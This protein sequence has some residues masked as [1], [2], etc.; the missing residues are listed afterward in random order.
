MTQ[1]SRNRRV[2]TKL[3]A[4]FVAMS[5]QAL[6]VS[7]LVLGDPQ[8]RDWGVAI[9]IAA[10]GLIGAFLVARVPENAVSWLLA[11]AGVVGAVAGFTASMAPDLAPTRLSSWQGLLAGLEQTTWFILLLL[12]VGFMPLY[13]PTGAV[14]SRRWRW[15][16]RL[17]SV[18]VPPII[19]LGLFSQRICLAPAELGG[20]GTWVDNPIGIRGVPDL[21]Y[22]ALGGWILLALLLFMVLS[23]ASLALRYHRSRGV[24]RLQLKL[25]A[26]TLVS[27]I[28]LIFIQEAVRSAGL[29]GE[30]GILPVI[31]DL[32]WVAIPASAAVAVLRYRLFEIDRIISR[33]ASYALVAVLI[34][35]VFALPALAIPASISASNDLVI[36]ASTLVAA[37]LFN[38]IRRR[39]Q[40]IVDRRFD[41]ARYDASRAAEAFGTTLRT[42]SD[43]DHGLDELVRVT[44][45][46]LYPAVVGV[47]LRDEG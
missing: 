29:S 5:V 4:L 40:R 8:R 28:V 14:P 21:E 7:G 26:F 13:F 24:E 2:V 23:V 43:P 42:T 19:L 47:W 37:A 22:S 1:L 25:V 12:V 34:G 33:T 9:G 41:R 3:I 15:V 16:S 30:Q 17:G 6:I 46:T 38:P 20:C 44:R 35:A 10:I 39:V 32:L 31:D 11:A 36:A 45:L 27:Y 18:C